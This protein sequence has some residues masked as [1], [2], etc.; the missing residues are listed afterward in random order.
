MKYILSALLATAGCI[1][2]YGTDLYPL[3]ILC[4]CIPGIILNP[5]KLNDPI[6]FKPINRKAQSIL[7]VLIVLLSLSVFIIFLIQIPEEKFKIL[8]KKWYFTGII[9]LL[10]MAS[11][12][13]RYLKDTEKAQH[14]YSRGFGG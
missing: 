12:T 5:I 7:L 3:G 9:W 4:I 1:L 6:K 2:W 8:F 14:L 11:F 13:F 10:M